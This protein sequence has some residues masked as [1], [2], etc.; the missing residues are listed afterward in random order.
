MVIYN[1]VDGISIKAKQTM[2]HELILKVKK[3]HSAL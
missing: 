2:T 1:I 3:F